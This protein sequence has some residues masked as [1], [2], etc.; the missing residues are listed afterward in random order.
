MPTRVNG[1]KYV[2]SFKCPITLYN[3]LSEVSNM[4][5][6]EISVTIRRALRLYI[7]FAKMALKAGFDPR[8]V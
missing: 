3:E 8:D 7:R 2:V 6:E 4:L 1:D 5:C